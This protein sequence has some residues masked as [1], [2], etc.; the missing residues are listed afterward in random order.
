M[1]LGLILKSIDFLAENPELDQYLGI[2]YYDNV[3]PNFHQYF[4]KDDINHWKLILSDS[5]G[6]LLNTDISDL[7]IIQNKNIYVFGFYFFFF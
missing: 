6:R 7:S 2:I 4:V 3:V 1:E 5:Q